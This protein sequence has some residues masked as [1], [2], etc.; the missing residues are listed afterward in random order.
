MLRD[1]A[2][3]KVGLAERHDER[4]AKNKKMEKIDA[5][6]DPTN[7]LQGSLVE[8]RPHRTRILTLA[9]ATKAA[10]PTTSSST[11]KTFNQAR[12]V[13]IKSITRLQAKAAQPNVLAPHQAVAKFCLRCRRPV[14]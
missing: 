3:S 4:H 13:L 2:A 5:G 6:T 1:L 7:I 12:S 11:R 10:K 9:V 14:W 8:Q